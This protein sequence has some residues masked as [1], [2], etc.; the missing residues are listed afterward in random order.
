MENDKYLSAI[1]E[2]KWSTVLCYSDVVTETLLQLLFEG[3]KPGEVLKPSLHRV[4]LCIE[5]SK[6]VLV[7]SQI[8]GSFCL[9]YPC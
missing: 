4:S 1:M 5:R 7:L 6:I 2:K 3:A 8:V 9:H